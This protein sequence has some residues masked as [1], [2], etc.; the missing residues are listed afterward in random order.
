MQKLIS[1]ILI[2]LLVCCGIYAI[3]DMLFTTKQKTSPITAIKFDSPKTVL[4][5]PI[6]EPKE[7]LK[8][9]DSLP[10]DYKIVKGKAVFLPT[11]N[12]IFN[13][14]T[15]PQ[16]LFE[17]L[18]ETYNYKYDT[19]TNN[20]SWDKN[21]GNA[22][23]RI[24][25]EKEG[26]LLLLWENIELSTK[27]LE[28]QLQENLTLVQQDKFIQTYQ[29]KKETSTIKISIAKSKESNFVAFDIIKN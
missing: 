13:T 24:N 15:M 2:M 10:Y 5:T 1:Y 20:N 3:S 29:Y 22:F 7:N 25:R 12:N 27:V 19:E 9:L 21:I 17:E 4:K 23:F 18:M 16:N 14:V 8:T 11:W 6:Q 28:Q 26:S